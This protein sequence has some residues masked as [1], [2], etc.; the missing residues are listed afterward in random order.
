MSTATDRLPRLLALVPYLLAHP[1][2]RLPEVAAIFGVTERQLR[3]DLDLLWVCG[4]PGQGPGDLI[5][6][7]LVGDT[8]TLSNADTI[9]RPLRLTR[10]EAL[11]LLVAL[12]TLA[13]LPGLTERAALDGALAKIERAAGDSARGSGR[14]AVAV[15]APPDVLATLQE[16]RTAQRRVHLRYYVPGRDE[17]TE[18]DV[19]PMRLLMADGRW[20]L[21]GWCRSVEDVRLFRLDRIEQLAVLAE[22]AEPPPAAEP[23]DLRAGLYAPAPGDLA[24]EIELDP[25]ARWVADYYPCESAEEAPEGRL[26]VRLRT[27]D[28]RWLRRL[29]LRLGGSARVL[30]PAE[31]AGEVRREAAA[32]L[33]A[34][35]EDP[36]GAPGDL[37]PSRDPRP[38]KVPE[39]DVDGSAI[40]DTGGEPAEGSP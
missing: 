2:A 23:R 36:A 13:D 22:P 20:Y 15:E 24:V 18:R 35:G 25:A 37:L 9:A 38:L 6:V 10:D 7:E 8:V 29:A 17:T 16:A 19:D 3:G 30:A 12:R 34:Y 5:D 27:P 21:E 39:R 31:L 28:T 4:L 32:A 26:R 33:A 14:V 11:A 40:A 1:G